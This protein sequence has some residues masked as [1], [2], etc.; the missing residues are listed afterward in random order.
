MIPGFMGTQQRPG[1]RRPIPESLR[2]RVAAKLRP[3]FIA[4]RQQDVGS[5]RLALEQGDFETVRRLGH[6]M[7]GNGVSYGFPEISSIG[8]HLEAA[9]GAKDPQRV[10]EAIALLEAWT[11]RASPTEG[12]SSG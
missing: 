3:K 4:H 2:S 7:R 10:R 11:T 6:N 1:S 9:A 5:L 8:E 12:L